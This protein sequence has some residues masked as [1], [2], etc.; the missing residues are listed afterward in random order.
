VRSPIA[1]PPVVC[2]HCRGR[3]FKRRFSPDG[4]LVAIGDNSGRIGF[5]HLDPRHQFEGVWSA[6]P[7][8]HPLTGHNGGVGSIDFEP[9]GRT[10]VTLSDDGKLRL[11][12]PTQAS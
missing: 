3:R 8:G 4:K 12:I 2:R 5:W 11:W 7:D 6:K 9:G 10:L 1:P